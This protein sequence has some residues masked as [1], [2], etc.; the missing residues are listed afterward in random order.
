M[1]ERR[2]GPEQSS[3]GLRAVSAREPVVAVV[4]GAEGEALSEC[5][6]VVERHDSPGRLK[7][8]RRWTRAALQ[9]K[10]I[11][12]VPSSHSVSATPSAAS[13]RPTSRS[14]KPHTV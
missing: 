4:L 8:S 6:E 11:S 1:F 5:L 3:T 14:T 7:A 9:P 13:L 2:A 10:E 12:S